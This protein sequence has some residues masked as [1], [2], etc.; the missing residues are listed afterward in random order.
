MIRKTVVGLICIIATGI[1]LRAAEDFERSYDLV[2][3]RHIIIDNKM[4]DVKV[5]VYE[6]H[7]L[8]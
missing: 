8:G 2:P 1:Q 6:S 7:A 5:S 4:G 3:G